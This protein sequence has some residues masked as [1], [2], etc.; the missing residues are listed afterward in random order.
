MYEAAAMCAHQC[1]FTT[2]GAYITVQSSIKY[3]TSESQRFGLLLGLKCQIVTVSVRYCKVVKA[4]LVVA[5]HI[6]V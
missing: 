5:V 4:R 6:P 1:G 2:A 3:T